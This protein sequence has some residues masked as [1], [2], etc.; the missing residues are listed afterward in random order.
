MLLKY[1][2]GVLH[3]DNSDNTTVPD[4]GHIVSN[5]LGD[6]ITCFHILIL[7]PFVDALV[8]HKSEVKNIILSKSFLLILIYF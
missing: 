2:S 1:T 8:S 5:D 7:V 6:N 4:T 3:T